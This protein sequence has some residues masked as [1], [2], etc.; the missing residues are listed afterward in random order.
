Q[1]R[2][3]MRVMSQIWDDTVNPN[4]QQGWFTMQFVGGLFNTSS[5][6]SGIFIGDYG[7]VFLQNVDY[8]LM[9]T[10]QAEVTTQPKDPAA[11]EV[12]QKAKK[13]I[14]GQAV[15]EE[16]RDKE[17]ILYD[18]EQV[19]ALKEKCIKAF[20]HAAN[21]RNLEPEQWVVLVIRHTSEE[22]AVAAADENAETLI[23][24]TSTMMLRAAKK[25]IDVFAKKSDNLEQF[26]KTVQ[27]L[28]Y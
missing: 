6:T 9:P 5:A 12:W 7:V 14:Q 11:D 24:N 17:A 3:D 20:R 26:M 25:D 8:P 28:T 23:D 1:I 19:E 13:K 22:N 16:P 21:I 18:E 27:V 2:E 15:E 4:A 10:D